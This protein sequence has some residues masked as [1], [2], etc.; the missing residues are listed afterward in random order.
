[1]EGIDV[2]IHLAA[3]AHIMDDHSSNPLAEYRRINVD[4]T[5]TLA[6]AASNAGVKRLIFLSSTKVNGEQT[7]KKPYAA[8]DTPAPEN[9]YG[10]SKAEAEEK[11]KEIAAGTGLE[12]VIIRTPLVYG[13]GVGANF[14]SLVSLA[15]SGLPLPFGAITKNRRSL[16]YIGNLVDVLVSATKHPTASGQTFLVRDGTDLSTEKLL[17]LLCAAFGKPARMISI[18]PTILRGLL[19]LLGKKSIADRLLS[20]LAVD[21]RMTRNVLGWSPAFSV[22]DGLKQTVNWYQTIKAKN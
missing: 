4:G 12:T 1:M 9:A 14:L 10:I 19:S 20:S 8:S 11:L 18:P 22:E 2:V 6:E 13:P 7:F 17:R 16:I 3:R 5:A 15:N 21:D